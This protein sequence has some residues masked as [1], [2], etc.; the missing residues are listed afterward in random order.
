M[1]RPPTAKAFPYG[2]VQV[3]SVEPRQ[4]S[5]SESTTS[6]T[7][8][9]AGRRTRSTS[10]VVVPSESSDKNKVCHGI[11]AIGPERILVPPTS[12]RTTLDALRTVK[13]TEQ[14]LV[15]HLP[16]VAGPSFIPALRT[17][18]Y[19][20]LHLSAPMLTQGYLAFLRV[21]TGY[22]SSLVMPRQELD[23]SQ[24]SVAVQALRDFT[25]L[26]ACDAPCAL[27]F[28]QAMFVFNILTADI[29]RTAH[30]VVRGSLISA[31]Q[32]Y[33]MLIQ[34]PI[35]DTV[36]ICPVLIDIVECLAR[37]EVPV[38]RPPLPDRIIVDRYAGVCST[39]LP[40]LY[41]L[42]ERSQALK[43]AGLDATFRYTPFSS[44]YFA[45]ID[46]A[47]R[48]WKPATPPHFL[49]EYDK[50]EIM[51]MMTQAKT[52]RLAGLLVI[53]RLR[54]PFGVEDETAE[55]Y[56]NS[57]F[58]EIQSFAEAAPK[59][60]TALPVVFPLVLAM[61]EVD[62]PGQDILN[63]LSTYTV[64]YICASKLLPF[65]KRVRESR[66]CGFDGTWFDLAET[67]LDVAMVP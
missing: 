25:V 17:A 23:I 15:I 59:G 10:T 30:S 29:S 65:V 49:D 33:P 9:T 36:T 60:S 64:Q 20:V 13:D 48:E 35:M 8:P 1:G 52:Y 43:T 61:F 41:D 19:S 11:S 57:I 55:Q 2:N 16:F 44:E 27:L 7:T 53:H 14:F 4:R 51:M 34:Y 63:S 38:I 12:L 62:G 3:W 28:G 58:S 66:K 24:A 56:A 54:Y 67:H 47:I 50:R 22:Q 46:L 32:W 45:D 40:H 26:Q 21:M 5:R 18:A 42:C 31:K 6:V 37:R 39:L